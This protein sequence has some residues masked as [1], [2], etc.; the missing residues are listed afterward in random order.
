VAGGISYSIGLLFVCCDDKG[1]FHAVWH[2]FV[3]AG[4]AF[5]FAAI[6][7]YVAI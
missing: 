4:M 7:I 2:L 3:I 5:H 1:Y 6:L